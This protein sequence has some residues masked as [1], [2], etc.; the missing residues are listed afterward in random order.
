MRQPF[1][2]F[3]TNDWL[4]DQ[5][6][7]MCSSAARGLWID[8]LC[9]MNNSKR[10]GFLE[11]AKGAPLSID[12]IGRLTGADKGESYGLVLELTEMGVLSTE[13]NTGIIYCR[14][15]VRDDEKSKKGRETGSRGGNPALTVQNPPHSTPE[16]KS[17]IPEVRS[18]ISLRV[19]L[20]PTLKG[21]EPA[22]AAMVEEVI[23]CRPEFSKLNQEQIAQ[24]IHNAAENPI[25]EQNHAEFI[26]DMVNS[27]KLPNVPVKLYAKYLSGTG[28]PGAE[29][30]AEPE[31]IPS[32]RKRPV[33]S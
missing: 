31:Y 33:I 19:T 32:S 30:T 2:K 7:R 14:R 25:R 28:K 4:A 17:Y 26:S 5:N 6:L 21:L 10:K 29:G 22:A 1:L 15:M 13:D 12:L 18:H 23:N 24:A 11:D 27:L 20:N 3:F 9:I 16:Y 8:L